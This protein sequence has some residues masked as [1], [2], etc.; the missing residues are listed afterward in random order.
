MKRRDFIISG[1]AALA[2]PMIVRAQ[3]RMPT[4]GFLSSGSPDGFA[5]YVTAFRNGL[6]ETGYFEGW[7]V[8]VEYRWAAGHLDR[9]PALTADLIERK[10][11]VIFADAQAALAAKA[12][13]ATVPIVFSCADDPLKL[14][15]V[16]SLHQPG[17]NI[18]GVSFHVSNI[19][20]KQLEI[21]HA[22]IS[23]GTVGYLFYS[24]TPDAERE[25]KDADAVARTFELKLRP[26][27]AEG[28]EAFERAFETFV[29]SKADAIVVNDSLQFI[30][31]RD[32]IVMLAAHDRVIAIYDLRPWAISGGL[33]SCGPS[34][35]DANR[36]CALYVAR[37][38]KGAVAADMP[39]IQSTKIEMVVNLKTAKALGLALPQPLILAANEVIE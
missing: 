31:Q 3:P 16:R 23:T 35:E 27:G 19:A 4:I 17:S 38:L 22:M 20:T 11:G 28:A 21:L 18:T 13:T 8:A 37:I 2:G 30:G 29:R 1:G 24:E 32:R 33:I 10:V 7:N 39:I 36:Q 9:L 12:V 5:F 15:L 6:R 26:A 14:G 34:V 25:S